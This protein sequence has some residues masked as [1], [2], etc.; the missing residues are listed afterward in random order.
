MTLV[1]DTI[2]EI[3][4]SDI[5]LL[6]SL[7]VTGVS[8]YIARSSNYPTKIIRKPEFDRIVN[9]G[10]LKLVLNYEA[11]GTEWVQGYAKG[12]SDGQWARAYAT[13][14]GWPTTRP[15][16]Q[17]IDQT[18]SNAQLPIAA[19]YQHGFNVGNGG[20]PQGCYGPGYVIQYLADRGLISVGWQWKD[21]TRANVSA[22]HIRQKY[23]TL[24]LPF[25]HD[26]NTP[27]TVDYGQH[28]LFALPPPP[29]G[30]MNEATITAAVWGQPFTGPD[31]PASVY[32]HDTR[33][34]VGTIDSRVQDLATTLGV[35][36]DGLT[37]L[38]K[39]VD[40][41]A[42]ATGDPDA[43]RAVIRD[44]LNKTILTAVE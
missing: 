31:A 23:G 40:A 1:I 19:E 28:P 42:A 18:V 29:E 36:L 22:A 41:L 38:T 2:H 10:R 44:E 25:S 27:L 21:G 39:K 20:A 8:R 33:L 13:S 16:T 12:A 4:V 24:A 26:T 17:S 34:V 30:N 9:D 7:G 43:V 32:L 15:I 6:L 5:N 35:V 3:Q 37:V 11:S 14:L